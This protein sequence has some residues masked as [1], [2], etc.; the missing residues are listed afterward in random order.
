M[1]HR[2]PRRR[3]AQLL[4][5]SNVLFAACTPLPQ[6]YLNS[7][8]PHYDSGNF[9]SD[10][11]QC[12]NEN[13]PAIVTTFDYET[14]SVARVNEVQVDGCMTRHGWEPVSTAVAWSPPLWRWPV[15]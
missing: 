10:L 3:L 9:L 11:T 4:M 13:A 12:R 8:H 2:N 14:H 15:W 7:L 5:L 6:R 1:R